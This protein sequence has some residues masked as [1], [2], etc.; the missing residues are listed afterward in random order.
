LDGQLLYGLKAAAPEPPRIESHIGRGVN[1][2]LP[3]A[4][5][6]AAGRGRRKR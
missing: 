1:L 3:I 4:P 2:N 5:G 6:A